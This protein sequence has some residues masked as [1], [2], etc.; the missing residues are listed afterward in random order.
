MGHKDAFIEVAYMF[1]EQLTHFARTVFENRTLNSYFKFL[2][3]R[4][5]EFFISVETLGH[6]FGSAED[7]ILMPYF[8]VYGMLRYT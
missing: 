8:S 1:N 2:K 4:D 3:A 5:L 6:S 7:V